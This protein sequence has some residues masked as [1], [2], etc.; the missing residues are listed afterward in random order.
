MKILIN[1]FEVK[2]H[3]IT[4]ALMLLKSFTDICINNDKLAMNNLIN[5]SI[6]YTCIKY[7][8]PLS[9][10]SNERTFNKSKLI[11]N[12]LQSTIPANQLQN[13]ML[14]NTNKGMLDMVDFKRLVGKIVGKITKNQC[15]VINNFFLNV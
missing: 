15:L 13:L 6:N 10:L 2:D 14:L 1:N 7:V 12:C 9:T 4:N 8:I 3:N 5:S 11:I